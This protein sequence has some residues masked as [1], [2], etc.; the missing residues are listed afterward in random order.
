MIV[1]GVRDGYCH[2]CNDLI[3]DEPVFQVGAD[4]NGTSIAYACCIQCAVDRGIITF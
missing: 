2:W 1:W 4:T 3:D